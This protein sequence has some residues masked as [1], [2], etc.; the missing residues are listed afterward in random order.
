MN[1]PDPA[2]LA[3]DI[4]D[5]SHFDGRIIA[6]SSPAHIRAAAD[7]YGVVSAPL[8]GA[9]VLELGC[10]SGENLLAFAVAYPQTQVVGV[11]ASAQAV[12]TGMQRIQALGLRN[13]QLHCLDLPS[14]DENF[15]QFDYIIANGMYGRLPP[16]QSDDLLRICRQNLTADGLAFVSYNTYPGS[17]G[18]D[19]LREAMLLHGR[20]ATSAEELLGSARAALGLFIEG[21]H[22]HNPLAA[23]LT[24]AAYAARQ[25]P[26]EAFARAYLIGAEP[27]C[28]FVAF[29]DRV[30][31]FG[32]CHLGDAKP[33]EELPATF[34]AGVA[35][36][37]SL[38]ALGQP[39]SVR[40]QYLDFAVGRAS[41]RSLL[42]H[43][44]FASVASGLPDP[45]RLRGLY[46]A[47]DLRN[48]PLT[49]AE[50][51]NGPNYHAYRTHDGRR[52]AT[53]DMIEIHV[54][55]VLHA[56]WPAA[57]AFEELAAAVPARDADPM[58][59]AHQRGVLAALESLFKWD[60]LRLRTAAD[61]CP[62][63]AALTLVA[64]LREAA[65]AAPA[66]ANEVDWFNVWHEPMTLPL[67]P[68]WRF[69]LPHLN[70]DNEYAQLCALLS[71]GLARGLAGAADGNAAA[72]ADPAAI[73]ASVAG[74]IEA[75][76][77][78]G[79][80]HASS[81]VWQR[82]YAA[83]L[84]DADA[85]QDHWLALLDPL[86]WHGLRA[87]RLHADSGDATRQPGAASAA[88]TAHAASTLT[89]KDSDEYT[90][91]FRAGQ[92]EDA[93]TL[94]QKLLRKTPRN[95]RAH[96]MLASAWEELGFLAEARNALLAALRLEPLNADAHTLLGLV[97]QKS[98]AT[99]Q[100]EQ[101]FFRARAIE[102]AHAM[103]LANIALRLWKQ[104]R[105]DEAEG[106]FKQALAVNPL[107]ASAQSNYGSLLWGQ[108]R[109][110]E[111]ESAYRK[112]LAANPDFFP[113]YSNLLF[114]MSHQDDITVQAL[115]EEHRKF[116]ARAQR[117]VQ[118][119]PY[120][121]GARDRSPTR[122]LRVGFVSADLRNHAVASF[123][124]PAWNALDRSQFE[125]YAYSNTDDE[126]ATSE[127]LKQHARIWR[128]VTGM[129][130]AA[131]AAQIRADRID[132]LFD[133]SG[134]TAGNRL[135]AFAQKPAPI[136][137]SWLGYPQSTG[138]AAMD[139]YLMDKHAVPLGDLAS[140]FVEKLV[141]MPSLS[142][143]KPSEHSGPITPLPAL[144]NGH[145]TFASFNRTSKI[146]ARTVAI[147]S[148][149]LHGVSG[150]RM[151]IGDVRDD[152]TRASLLQRF[153]ANGI[154]ASRLTFRARMEMAEYLRCHAEVDIALDTYPYTGG[155]TTNH[156]LWMG[157]PVLTLKGEAR[158][159]AQTAG[160]LGR[161]GLHDW[162]CTSEEELVAKAVEWAGDSAR[163]A[164]L[165]AGMRERLNQTPSRQAAEVVRG[166]ESAMRRMWERWTKGLPAESFSVGDAS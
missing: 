122:A 31:Q 134:H 129:T 98:S 107:L 135:L 52:V 156:S 26:D 90:R 39:A 18:Q 163:L 54:A 48:V 116:G 106:Y 57:V 79:A 159:S 3:A 6:C 142:A 97:L 118:R 78:R 58:G 109:L 2:R 15:G 72:P 80:I 126:D 166:L 158:V 45:T 61:R 16:G 161:N 102:P 136:Q 131:L 139:Y 30:Q 41:R 103:A 23:V 44:E 24:P 111:A 138:I 96:R 94:M 25:Q 85:A 92:Y 60:V 13:L 127:R 141:Y 73:G 123:L 50:M 145:I 110:A 105:R 87:R 100:A 67:T 28:Y 71:D 34:G 84:A 46:V 75:L 22:Q 89:Q 113:G 86:V 124:E 119:L 42:M 43:H 140:Q 121:P 128:R 14:L 144:A 38:L 40:Q 101:A 59:E 112:A 29:A 154:E 146:G 91:L 66:R 83:V 63:P 68:Q 95:A 77:E 10:G 49:A 65:Q 47:A 155:T 148:K 21:I 51:R 164:Q 149:V 114:S 35:M 93:A 160:I 7:L 17:K 120:G 1:S 33:A 76:R 143:F 74:L 152:A 125:L 12:A 104:R 81:D 8:A 157:V 32:L 147:W 69:L 88:R 117:M 62:E 55:E 20:N 5:A 56:A 133:L 99:K 115:T 162:I 11:D 19:V 137:I 153:E 82:H 53:G 70:G 27:A 37:N 4:F 151:L 132:V 64:G 150:S 108:G 9:R 130:D 165:R 36:N